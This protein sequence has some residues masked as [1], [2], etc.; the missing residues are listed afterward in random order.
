L[1]GQR[2]FVLCIGDMKAI[3]KLSAILSFPAAYQLFS[4]L[5]GGEVWRVYTADY[6][7]PATGEKV[8]DIGCGPADILNYLPAIDYTGFDISPEYIA[9]AQKRFGDKGRFYCS[10]V[11]LATVEQE[12]GTFNLVFATGVLHHLDDETA[13]K[14]FALAQLALRPGG[15]LITYDGCFVPGQSRIARWLLSNDRGK[16]VRTRAAYERLASKNFSRVQSE[17]RHDLLRIPYTHLIM[18]CSN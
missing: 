3:S 10:D 8:L 1:T 6:L 9:A 2:D 11:G 18:R 13:S 16:F 4:R 14:L 5:V 12:Q 7:K 15:R 17:L